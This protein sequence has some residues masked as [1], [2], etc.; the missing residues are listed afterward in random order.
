[1]SSEIARRVVSSV[2]NKNKS[3]P[4]FEQLTSREKEILEYLSKGFLYKEIAS[5]LFISKETVKK[6]IHNI[7]EK[8]QVQS[9]IG[10]MYKAFHK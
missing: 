3:T 6:H 10:A 1:M 7:Y 4:E 5:E 8:L 2:Q 9:R